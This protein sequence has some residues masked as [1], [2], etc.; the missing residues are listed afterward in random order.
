[1]LG[2]LVYGALLSSLAGSAIDGLSVAKPALTM[3]LRRK[4]AELPRF[5]CVT[6][7]NPRP[8]AKALFRVS[9]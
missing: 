3:P 6:R 4:V 9:S 1:L 8:S 5:R 7:A 2:H